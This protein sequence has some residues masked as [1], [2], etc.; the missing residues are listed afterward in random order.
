MTREEFRQQLLV[1]LQRSPY[2][3]FTV[4]LKTGERF[5]VDDPQFVGHNVR[6]NGSAGAY[7]DANEQIFLFDYTNVEEFIEAAAEASV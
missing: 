1:H 5:A 6:D 2:R 4:V 7:I 3:P